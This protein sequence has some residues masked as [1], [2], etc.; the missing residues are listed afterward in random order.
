MVHG[1]LEESGGY[2]AEALELR[3]RLGDDRRLVEPLIDRAWLWLAQD[4]LDAARGGFLDCL[5]LARHV[6]D[7]FNLAEALAGLSTHA[8]LTGRWVDA[9]RLAGAS[10]ALHEQIGAPP[11]ESVTAIQERALA[12]AKD[13][14]AV[15]Y[16]AHSPR[17][18]ASPRKPSSRWPNSPP[19][20]R[21]PAARAEL[22]GAGRARSPSSRHGLAAADEQAAATS[23]AAPLVGVGLAQPTATKIAW[24]AR[25]TISV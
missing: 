3:R 13:R 17:G 22:R 18:G 23:T 19:P 4:D 6:G 20:T 14:L 11:W 5:A 21:S 9:A 7:Q 1:R 24:C 2:L 25:R 8:A 16:G 15:E 12:R 10:A